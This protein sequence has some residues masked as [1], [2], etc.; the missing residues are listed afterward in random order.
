MTYNF[1]VQRT[2]LIANVP[3]THER[4]SAFLTS[5]VR[6]G[7]RG[8]RF[9]QSGDSE[10]GLPEEDGPVLEARCWDPGVAPPYGSVGMVVLAKYSPRSADKRSRGRSRSPRCWSVDHRE[11]LGVRAM[12]KM[13][14]A[15]RQEI[16][17]GTRG[18]RRDHLIPEAAVVSL[19]RVRSGGN[20]ADTASMKTLIF[21][22]AVVAV[23]A[24][25]LLYR[26]F[27]SG[28]RGAIGFKNRH[29]S[30]ISTLSLTGFP[31]VVECRTLARGEHSFN[32]L[33]PQAI[34]DE[35]TITWRFVIDTTDRTA[36]V[37]LAG[38]TKD[39]KDGE[40][41]FVLS[42]GGTW[43]VEYAPHLQLEKLQRGE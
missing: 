40:L 12:P 24:M 19:L 28:Y 25:F 1:A 30:E 37:S 27:K 4:Q 31:K 13:P 8:W 42:D 5:E 6:R 7:E 29:A 2:E 14:R 33:G 22:G 18:S 21:I 20:A 17:A 15:S 34:P 26:V 32:Y 41:F 35:V 3:R 23:L 16:T 39:A 36:R 38:V 43:T 9:G 11:S 10:G